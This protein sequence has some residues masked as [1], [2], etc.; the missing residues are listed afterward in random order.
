M[1]RIGG[2]IYNDADRATRMQHRAALAEDGCQG[3]DLRAERVDE[4]R[5]VVDSIRHGDREFG[6][7]NVR[8]IGRTWVSSVKWRLPKEP[9][10]L[11]RFRIGLSNSRIL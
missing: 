10:D 3:H 8:T 11:S 5:M 4:I 7:V 2:Q 1:N 9:F 6:V